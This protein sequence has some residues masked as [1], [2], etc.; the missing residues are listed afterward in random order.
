MTDDQQGR[1]EVYPNHPGF[2][3]RGGASEAAANKVAPTLRHNQA[4]TL[5]ALK[6]IGEPMTADELAAY[7]ERSPF[8]VRPRVAELNRL[9]AIKKTGERRKNASGHDAACWIPAP[10]L[11]PTEPGEAP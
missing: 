4:A 10:E 3:E 6:A 8:S 7:M 9:G 1:E 11:A 5:N 2:K